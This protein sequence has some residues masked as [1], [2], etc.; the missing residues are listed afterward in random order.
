MPIYSW[1]NIK[2]NWSFRDT[3]H[4]NQM[5]SILNIDYFLKLDNKLLVIDLLF[6]TILVFLAFAD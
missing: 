3:G 5:P 2:F 6:S 4:L 1:Q